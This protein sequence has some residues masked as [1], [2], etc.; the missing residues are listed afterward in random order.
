MIIVSGQRIADAGFRRILDE[1]PDIN[2]VG[3]A[4]DV[5]EALLLVDRQRPDVCLLNPRASGMDGATRLLVSRGVAV[6]VITSFSGD[7]VA[8]AIK[9]YEALRGG[10][11]SVLTKDVTPRVLVDAVHAAAQGFALI[12]FPDEVRKDFAKLKPGTKHKKPKKPFT[13]REKEVL[14]ALVVTQTCEVRTDEEIAKKLIITIATVK[15]HLI[16]LRR[17]VGASNRSELAVW[18]VLNQLAWKESRGFEEFSTP[19]EKMP[20]ILG[21][22]AEELRWDPDELR[23]VIDACTAS[24]E[25]D[26]D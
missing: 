13:D 16:S 26:D 23:A 4:I 22:H 1:Q 10:A 11:L 20:D 15:S 2:V 5:Q 17:K 12:S 18:A 6:V 7:N 14:D 8:V 24:P 21:L 9:C 25:E 19:H 3:E